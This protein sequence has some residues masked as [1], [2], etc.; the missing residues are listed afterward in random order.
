MY[1]RILSLWLTLCILVSLVPPHIFAANA[2]AP[3]AVSRQASPNLSSSTINW[4]DLSQEGS[5]A[6]ANIPDEQQGPQQSFKDIKPTDWFYD[7]VTYV[8]Q[9]GIFSGTDKDSFSPGGTMTRAMYVTVLGRMAG[10]DVSQ[11]ATLVFTDVQPTAWYAPYV[12]WAVDKG[13]TSG[14]GNHIFSPDAPITREQ[15]ATLTLRFFEVYKIPYQTNVSLTSKPKDISNISPWAVDAIVKLWQAGLISGDAKGN[16]NPRS[17][18]SRA[19]AATFCM[20]S[21]EVV[22]AVATPGSTTKPSTPTTIEQNPG[23]SGGQSPSNTKYIISF[24][25]NG[26]S[27]I[28][29]LTLRQGESLNNLQVP[30]KVGAIFQGWY[31][32]SGLTQVLLNNDV[33]SGNMTL[34][35]KYVD[36]VEEAVQSIPS[37]T[38]LDQTP[39]FTAQVNDATGSMT[40]DQVKAGL[41]FESPA[42][43]AFAGIEVTGSNGRF[44]VAAKGGK[45][46]EGNTY[47]L[48]LTDTNLSFAGQDQT[49]TIYIFS[50]AKQEVVNLPLNSDMIY[51]PFADLSGMTNNGTS[52]ASASIPVLFASVGNSGIDLG[53]AN[54]TNGTFVYTGSTIIQI[55]ETVTIYEGIRPDQRTADTS[56]AD[57]GD[58][59]YVQITAINGNTYTYTSADVKNVLVKPNV[60]PVSMASD[61][62][63]DATNHSITVEHSTMNFQDSKYAP[64]GLN[65]LTVVKAGDFIAFYNGEFGSG[66]S[67]GYG[68][69]TSIT[70]DAEMD[71]IAYTDAAEE[72]ITGALDFY[73]KQKIDGDQL[74]S[75][76]DSAA[77]EGQIKQEAVASGFVQEAANYLSAVALQTDTFKQR[78]EVTALSASENDG[79]KVSV[80]NL[81]VVPSISD[82]LKHFPGYTGASVTLQVQ[83]D[84]VI[85]TDDG[86]DDSIVIHL[87]STFVE[88]LR[89]ELG[90]NGDTQI[91]WYW[92]IPIIK[93]YMITANLDAYT[94]TGI[95]V[96]AEIGTMAKEKL[97]DSLVDWAEAE[98][99]Q[100][101]ATEIQALLDGVGDSGAISGDTLRS[102]Y[103]DILENE[104]EWVPLLSKELVKKS[105]RVCMGIIEIEFTVNLVINM[106]PN[107]T[108]GIDFNYKSAKRYSVTVR[109]LSGSGS[110]NTVSLSGDGEYKFKF[111][112]LG[113]LGLR[114]GIQ[115]ELKAG[116]LSV[117]LNSI[118]F[119]VEAGP[120]LNLWG[121][122]YYELTNSAAGKK[123]KSLGAL[124]MEVGIY[125][126]SALA[127]QLGDGLLTTEV[128]IY[129][130]EWPLYTAGAQHDVYDFV[131][132]QDDKLGVQLTGK[133]TSVQLPDK[134]FTM[135]VMDLKTGETSERTFDQSNFTIEVDSPDFIYDSRTKT[136]KMK[137]SNTLGAT[138]NLTITWKNAPLAF[139]SAQIKRTFSL[140]F[141]AASFDW[142]F[143][144]YFNNGDMPL[145][146][147]AQYNAKITVPKDPVRLGYT[148]AGWYDNHEGG[149]KYTIPDRMPAV[150]KTLYAR[151]VPDADTPYTIEHY[152]RDPNDNSATL[153]DKEVLRG[154]TDSEI[155]LTSTKYV[156]QG[157]LPQTVLKGV[158]INA[159]GSTVV[160]LYYLRATRT[161]TFKSGYGDQ[162]VVRSLT[163]PIGQN[164][165][166]TP[167]VIRPGYTFT[168]WS[169]SVPSIVPNQD[170]TYTATW[171]AKSDTPYKVVHLQQDIKTGVTGL[172]ILGNTYTVVD[173]ENYKGTTD[174]ATITA[175]AKSYE[176]FTLDSSA[177]GTLQSSTIA[178]D[179]TTVLRLYY[180]RNLYPVTYDLNGGTVL[181]NTE[182]YFVYNLPYGARIMQP[183]VTHETAAFGG[184]SPSKPAKM[185][186]PAYALHFKAIWNTGSYVVTHIRQDLNGS[187]TISESET[188]YSSENEAVTATPKSYEGFTYD[189]SVSGTVAS[190]TVSANSPLQLKLYYKRNTYKVTYDANGGTGGTT[191][192]VVYGTD[193]SGVIQPRVTR[194]GYTFKGWLPAIPATMP[195]QDVT[196]S[197]QWEPGVVRAKTPTADVTSGAVP[198]GTYVHL[199]AEAGATIRYTSNN[200]V[201]TA[202]I[203]DLNSFTY[204]AGSPI[205]VVNDMNIKAVAFRNGVE[206]SE[207]LTLSYTI[208]ASTLPISVSTVEYIGEAAGSSGSLLKVKFSKAVDQ[209]SAAEIGNY[210]V[211]IQSGM[212]PQMATVHSATWG[213][214]GHENEVTLKVDSLANVNTGTYVSIQVYGVKTSD[215]SETIQSGN[216]NAGFVMP[217]LT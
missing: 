148:F 55:G 38:I 160:K 123:A 90:I 152:L 101:I 66:S 25:T 7:A 54:V 85:D 60:L 119:E 76:A 46:E 9:S 4:H 159:N 187:Y 35:A 205:Y 140:T 99:V 22:K 52:V 81:T 42:N 33:V 121:Y 45:F 155:K 192:N 213:G 106:N 87:T 100:N 5:V 153:A 96:T 79:V 10:V 198:Y 170:T 167:V 176:G 61:T 133:V 135:N 68:L 94:Y 80:E 196:Y 48:T 36:S 70:H 97:K 27:A 92:F 142:G 163:L 174:A 134:L 84:I 64:L 188:I 118:G 201:P 216:Y 209:S 141:S 43:P 164:I 8:Q 34:Y 12:Q 2:K 215:L 122:F 3:E 30:F 32:D 125:L 128:P 111:Y 6:A 78:Y 15:M 208:K 202:D 72:Q 107:L 138:G 16:F 161:M 65:D 214:V 75:D 19:E 95:T 24:E 120:Y 40:A 165:S 145:A 88:E 146:I 117:D 199:S 26:G 182:P 154:P 73:Q 98:D 67:A 103:Q 63:G 49:T 37:I 184:W 169:P 105:A 168:G 31:K 41:K 89:F 178:G 162:S 131:Y 206:A 217:D 1:K 23:G 104:T 193:M 194:A 211:W 156:N 115:M 200:A 189:S 112:V 212:P 144:L 74:L 69:I 57:N 11:Y 21:N 139:T 149:S 39:S 181:G 173:E 157:Y 82:K 137:N 91:Q 143:Q 58:V 44:T 53:S 185:T 129:E 102:K 20:R 204:N 62:D 56:D 109:V 51:L 179:G 127:A 151:W 191:I 29:S 180:K 171:T 14:S 126:E 172:S 13:I 113:T 183:Y 93:D 158:Y 203:T 71:V 59:A 108:V 28:N 77:L 83:C 17:Q 132:P 47:Q 190:G 177:P 195:A 114:A 124:Y 186:M 210:M 166:W 50:I 130:N 18:A 175:T 150:F 116:I 86:N 207:V 136:L 110:S 197:A 147:A